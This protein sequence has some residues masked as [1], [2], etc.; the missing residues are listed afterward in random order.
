MSVQI[1]APTNWDDAL[2][3]GYRGLPVTDVYGALARDPVG[4]GRAGYLLKQPGRRRA[5]AHIRRIR[6]AGI[7]F[8]YLLNAPC[9]GNAI[10]EAG[11]RRELADH[12]R[13]IRD[14]GAGAVTVS[15]PLLIDIA[16]TVTPE[17]GVRVSA[18]AHVGTV[19]RAR[20]FEEMGVSEI[21]L[22]FQRNR[23]LATLASI[24]RAVAVDLNLVVNDI[25]L[26]HCPFRTSCYNGLGHSS[27]ERGSGGF[28]IDDN[29][30]RCFAIKL[31]RPVELLRSPWLRPQDLPFVESVTGIRRFKVSGRTKPTERILGAVR[32][33]SQCSFDGDMLDVLDGPVRPPQEGRF[34][35]AR[36]LL[37]ADRRVLGA[38]TALLGAGQRLLPRSRRNGLLDVIGETDADHARTLLGGILS[39]S[40]TTSAIRIDSAALDGFLQQVQGHD[41]DAECGV[42]CS[43]C[44]ARA[45]RA[46]EVDRALAGRI[47][48]ALRRVLDGVADG[49]YSIR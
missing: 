39:L 37:A 30:F 34:R 47:A 29:A 8:T 3:A 45:E 40:E 15:I 41:C 9:L 13:W 21:T 44:D 43:L 16:K 17:L 5:E 2:V 27:Q 6:D 4:G 33:Y 48:S 26:L 24:R 36:R 23:D 10:H 11:F 14:S 42:S 31:E 12:L 18:I 28:G 19:R 25:C 22:D 32:A 35:A 1:I 49:S 20:F 46:V 7:S 38:V